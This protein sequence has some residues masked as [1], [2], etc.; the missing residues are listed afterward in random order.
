MIIAPLQPKIVLISWLSRLGIRWYL[1]AGV[2]M[3]TYSRATFRST[4]GIIFTRGKELDIYCSLSYPINPILYI[5]SL[6]KILLWLQGEW[7]HEELLE[8]LQSPPFRQQ[9]DSFTY[10]RLHL[11]WC[12][13]F[14]LL[15][16]YFLGVCWHIL[17]FSI[18]VL[19]AAHWTGGSHS[20]WDRS[21]QM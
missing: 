2:Y 9:L 21:K 8:L 15:C 1:E 10:V 13:S 6:I 11:F 17:L 18:F 4:I 5:C 7:T 12:F 14:F 16:Y 3:A 20:V 19:G